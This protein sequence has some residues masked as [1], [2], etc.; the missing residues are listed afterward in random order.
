VTYDVYFFNLLINS[1]LQNML[2]DTDN[3]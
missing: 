2:E 1:A 3:D